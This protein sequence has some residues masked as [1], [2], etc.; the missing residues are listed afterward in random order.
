[1]NTPAT[2]LPLPRW[3][4]RVARAF[5]RAA[6]R[7]DTLASAQRDI[8]EALWQTL[9]ER[10]HHVLD[11]G[12]GTGYWTQRLA[13]HYPNATITGLDL[14]PGML[15]HAQAQYG[16]AIRWQQGDAAALPLSDASVDL[17][18]SNLAIQW[19]PDIGA[20]M[21][22]LARVLVPGGQARI[23]TLL[24]GT[25]SEVATAWQRPEALLQTPD[26]STVQRAIQQSGLRL[27]QHTRAQRRFF[28][29]DMNAVMA[30]IKGVGAQVARPNA[31]L[32]RQALINAQAR[33]ESLR[34]PQGLPVS[35]QCFTLHLEQTP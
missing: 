18:F 9:P 2:S 35:Y 7:Y 31:R 26:A 25:L 10:S 28:Y 23:T 20:V 21:Q 34:T 17:V 12:C 15:A 24:P 33:Y 16:D 32:T 29:S 14:A 1:M 11:L 4:E 19:C 13:S 22:E 5:S 27:T 8:G 30:S 6:P 3:Q